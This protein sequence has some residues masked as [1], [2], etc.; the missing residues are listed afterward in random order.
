VKQCGLTNHNIRISAVQGR[1]STTTYTRRSLCVVEAKAAIF[2]RVALAGIV[3]NTV[4]RIT[5]AAVVNEG[6]RYSMDIGSI[7]TMTLGDVLDGAGSRGPIAIVIT[8]EGSAG[9]YLVECSNAV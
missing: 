9:W 7:G 5:G 2:E 3:S 1:G 4:T 6:L 8:R